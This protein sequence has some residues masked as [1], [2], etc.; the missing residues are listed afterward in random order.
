[1]KG[2]PLAEPS[3]LAKAASWLLTIGWRKRGL[4]R[5]NESPKFAPRGEA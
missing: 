2:A 1:M 5:P 3:M 4:I